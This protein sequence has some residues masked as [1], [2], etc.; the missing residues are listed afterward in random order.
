MQNVLNYIKR[1]NS[2]NTEVISL[3]NAFRLLVSRSPLASQLLVCPTSL[4]L[5]VNPNGQW[6][7]V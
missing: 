7:S 3:A 5:D 1:Q 6:R 2:D 4:K